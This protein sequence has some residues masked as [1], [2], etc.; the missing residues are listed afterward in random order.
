MTTIEMMYLRQI[1]MDM[2]LDVKRKRS[3]IAREERRI[4]KL[5]RILEPNEKKMYDRVR[6]KLSE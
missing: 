5:K 2:E 3:D 4:R 6:E 1:I